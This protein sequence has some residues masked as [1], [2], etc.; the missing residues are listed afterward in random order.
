MLDKLARLSV[1]SFV[2]LLSAACSRGGKPPSTEPPFEVPVFA[3]SD[4]EAPLA[5]VSLKIGNAEP[6]VTDA[7]GIA[8]LQLRGRTGDELEVVV[9]CPDGFGPAASP[10]RITLYRVAAG[11]APLART[12]SCERQL[13]KVVAAVRVTRPRGPGSERSLR[14][15]VTRFGHTLATTD[16]S[17]AAHLAIEGRPGEHVDLAL[18]TSDPE[19]RLLRPQSPT[20]SFVIPERDETVVLEQVFE[21]EKPPPP[22]HRFAAKARRA[23]AP[24]VSTLPSKI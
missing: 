8:K 11:A 10:L 23:P 2:L 3:T 4:D 22:P 9:T 7:K 1:L 6:V 16:S 14:L 21:E 15:P 18:D 5:G 20:L 24:P 13:R 19:R 12:V 17:G